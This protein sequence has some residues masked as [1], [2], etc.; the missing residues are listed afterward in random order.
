MKMKLSFVSAQ[1]SV[2]MNLIVKKRGAPDEP[3]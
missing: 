3:R 1:K 2:K